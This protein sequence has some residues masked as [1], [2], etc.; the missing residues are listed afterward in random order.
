MRSANPYPD[1]R[2][3]PTDYV[4]SDGEETIGR[5]FLLKHGPDE[6]RWYWTMAVSRPGR[7]STRGAAQ[8]PAAATVGASS[9]L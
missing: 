6:G 8:R 3:L 5:V 7:R 2:F 9:K 1:G 4:A